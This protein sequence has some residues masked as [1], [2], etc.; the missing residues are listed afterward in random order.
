ML[1]E[2]SKE[3]DK[4]DDSLSPDEDF[5]S[6][7]LNINDLKLDSSKMDRLY[8]KNG[9]KTFKGTKSGILTDKNKESDKDDD[10]LSPDEDFLSGE[11]NMNDL[12]LD[13]LKIDRL[14]EKNGLKTFKGTKSG[15]V[16]EQSREN[17]LDDDLSS[18]EDF[19]S[20]GLNMNEL[21]LDQLNIDC[22]YDNTGSKMIKGTK[23]GLLT[24]VRIEDV[25]DDEG[26]TEVQ[27]SVYDIPSA[28]EDELMNKG[29]HRPLL[30]EGQG[31]RQ[32]FYI[33]DSLLCT[34]VISSKGV[35]LPEL[36]LSSKELVS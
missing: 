25:D 29:L 32:S 18:D 9:L 34:I 19:F 13:P 30:K 16:T 5:L 7:A 36:S 26:Y 33:K 17:D 20:G 15:I 22:L 28:F 10:S 8:E 6:G 11:L 2:K 1:A 4:D 35:S 23:T 14:Y 31:K 3:S 24:E 12:K 27:N 21:K